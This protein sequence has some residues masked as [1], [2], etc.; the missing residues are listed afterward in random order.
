MI[1]LTRKNF[2]TVGSLGILGM[3][4]G[5]VSG[6]GNAKTNHGSDTK[7]SAKGQQEENGIEYRIGDTVGTDLVRLTLNN[8]CFATAL[9]NSLPT[10]SDFT[11]NIAHGSNYSTLEYFTPK[12][13]SAEEDSDN[14]F[15]APKGGVFVYAEMTLECMDRNYLELDDSLDNEFAT[16]GY[17]GKHYQV[18]IFETTPA[19][20]EYG[21]RADA[22]GVWEQLGVSNLLLHPSSTNIYRACYL[23]PVEP[24]NLDEP[25]EI[26]F[27]LPVSDDT[28]ESFTF[29]VNQ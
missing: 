23:Y 3:M 5:G 27:Q 9:K 11:G 25:F 6:C 1:S 28:T 26:A 10:D 7:N 17:A 21:I 2:L 4:L 20:K 12:S 19:G 16:L 24:K 15:V 22:T 14:P 29:A 18:D 8:A 13:Y